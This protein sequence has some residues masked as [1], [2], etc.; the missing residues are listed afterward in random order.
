M[1]VIN[2]LLSSAVVLS[3]MVADQPDA[4]TER[5][6]KLHNSIFTLDT[7]C[8]TPMSLGRY[9]IGVRHEK[10]QGCYDLPRMK[11]GGLS[12]SCFAVYIGQGARTAEGYATAKERVMTTFGNLEG[13]FTKYAD[14]VEQVY[15]VADFKRIAKTG[16]RAILV[17]MENAYSIGVNINNID[18]YYAKGARMMGLVHGRNNDICDSATD[19]AMREGKDNG[20]SEFGQ[21]AIK[22][23]NELGI[24]IDL[25]HASTKS[26]FDTLALSKSPIMA[27]HSSA[28]AICNHPR[29]LSDDELL[30]L[31]KNGGV[32][33]LC[34]LSDYIKEREISPE[35]R[36]LQEDLDARIAEFGGWEV[37]REKPGGDEL[38]RES[39][40]LRTRFGGPKATVKDAVD[41]IDHIVKLIGIDHVGIGTDFDG[42]GGLVDCRDVTE[43]SNITIE[44][45]RRGYSDKAIK[46]IWGENAMR[47]FEKAQKNRVK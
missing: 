34:I 8:D 14:Q 18:E 7:H 5:A 25:S 45:V 39:R 16:K 15:T 46:K 19:N 20:V 23:M 22:R 42:G 6:L 43:L 44:L 41:H 21:K 9:D 4:I 10:G 11:E 12:A 47:V 24:V 30:A 37:L 38:L 17:S 1:I 32:I 2:T 3:G 28:R 40:A 35:Q 29:N 36:K 26:F 27:S 13:M 33:Q 31:K